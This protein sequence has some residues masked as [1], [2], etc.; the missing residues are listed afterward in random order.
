LVYRQKVSSKCPCR[1]GKKYKN[2]CKKKDEM[3]RSLINLGEKLRNGDLS[4]R[5]EISSENGEASS[6]K[7]TS[8]SIDTGYGKKTL[9]EDEITLSTGSSTGDSIDNSSAQLT[10]PVNSYHKPQIKTKGNA[11]VTNETSSYKISIQGNSKKLK[12]KSESGLFA[13]L[14]VAK[15]RDTDIGYLDVLFGTKGEKEQVNQSG[16]KNRPHIAFHPDGNC[17]FIRLSNY[18]CELSSVLDYDTRNKDIFP[19]TVEIHSSAHSESILIEF[20]FL[21]LEK[22]VVL[23]SAVFK[24]KT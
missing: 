23:K 10:V 19:S 24:Q 3:N 16:S 14:R 22:V 5:A 18:E 1:S 4:F 12:I 17:K 2:C 8:A 7:V 20:E 11:S 6:M 15:Q 21:A 9:L 13:I